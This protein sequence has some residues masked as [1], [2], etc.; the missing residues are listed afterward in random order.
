M[1][2]CAGGRTPGAHCSL[3]VAQPALTR[4]PLPRH[5]E[6][7]VQRQ[8]RGAKHCGPPAC[9]GVLA[10]APGAGRQALSGQCSLGSIVIF[11]FLEKEEEKSGKKKRK[12]LPITG[13]PTGWISCQIPLLGAQRTGPG[14]AAGVWGLANGVPLGDEGG[15]VCVM[16]MHVNR[17]ACRGASASDMQQQ[18]TACRVPATC[19]C[20][21]AHFSCPCNGCV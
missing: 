13:R 15:H 1:D 7:G 11:F 2:R 21:F 20:H 16:C 17:S 19:H 12:C 14:R 10:I 4:G 6:V 9:L 5:P 3:A 8:R 18:A